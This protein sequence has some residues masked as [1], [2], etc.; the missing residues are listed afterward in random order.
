MQGA[1]PE[2]R[3]GA[4]KAPVVVAESD[5]VAKAKEHWAKDPSER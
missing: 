3:D 2:W 5:S 1:D 4:P